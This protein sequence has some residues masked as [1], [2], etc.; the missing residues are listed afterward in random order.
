MTT[1]KIAAASLNQIPL[2][3]DG[4]K[5]RILAAISEAR[6]DKINLLC[7]QELCVSAYGCED[8]FLSEGIY[9][10]AYKT[11]S[12]IAKETS[13]MIVAIGCPISFE[14]NKYNG[15]FLIVDGK[16]LGAYAKHVLADGGVYYEQRWF[17]PWPL[18]KRGEL[19]LAGQKI[20]IGDYVFE[21]GGL[22]IAFEICEDAWTNYRPAQHCAGVDL[23]LNPSASHFAFSKFEVR[24]QIVSES[25]KKF[26]LSYL[27]ANA[28][29][30][31]SGRLI[32][33]GGSLFATKGKL[34]I[35]GERFSYSEVVLSPWSFSF[36]KNN[37]AFESEK[38]EII[39]TDFTFSE[40]TEVKQQIQAK[41]ES[42]KELK[43]QE[44]A[45]AVALGL[46]DYL[47]KSHSKGFVVSLS[48]GA[49]SSAVALLCAIMHKLSGEQR[50]LNE[51]LCCVYQKTENNSEATFL[52]ASELAKALNAEFYN[53]EISDLVKSYTDKVSQALAL[54]LSWD[55]HDVPLQNVQAR[56]R[57]PLVWLITNLKGF[58]LLATSNR[59][60]AAVGYTTMD[61]DTSGGLSPIGG[62]DK[63]F[64]RQWL[65]WVEKGGLE[66]IG[67]V[68]ALSFVNKLEPSAELRP[69]DRNQLQSVQTD[70]KDLM[71]YEV[72]DLIERLAIRDRLLESEV[73][74][75]LQ[76]ARSES[77][78]VLTA[79]VAKFFRLWKANQ[80]K[81]E[82]YAPCF[83]LDD[84][85]LDPKTWCRY[86]I[87]SV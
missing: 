34:Q 12:E 65:K 83:H 47:R 64:L 48:G 26:N 49:D 70:E 33:D 61:G 68:K 76:Q 7:F 3:W 40:S 22:K 82:R 74:A 10:L 42:S 38:F 13:K 55:K 1:I 52:A 73:L 59:S 57:S 28:L 35:P 11:I 17:E 29:G 80:W 31:E 25:S 67:E 24:K 72:L 66:E 46:Y 45:R 27:Y 5:K 81:R 23:V 18:G 30:N 36:K 58:L 53:F 9:D 60:E 87:L 63:A 8:M 2:D 6:K 78:E 37:Q 54:D 84:E 69:L 75:K 44:F 85:N 19:E 39:K 15:V 71:P 21:V 86:P 56:T 20:P 77:K 4:N 32:F 50:K 43:C 79:W 14:G 16:I 51:M 41:W 62:I